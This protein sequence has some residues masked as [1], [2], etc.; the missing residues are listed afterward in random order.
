M[1]DIKAG[2]PTLFIITDHHLSPNWWLIPLMMEF[3][4]IV[5]KFPCVDCIW[6]L[7]MGLS[8][9]MVSPKSYACNAWSSCPH[10]HCHVRI[11]SI[12]EQTWI[13][14]YPHYTT[15][16]PSWNRQFW[17]IPHFCLKK[18]S[19]T[20]CFPWYHETLHLTSIIFPLLDKS[21]SSSFL[22]TKI[23]R[24]FV[25]K[26]GS[27]KSYGLSSYFPVAD[28]IWWLSLHVSY[29]KEKIPRAV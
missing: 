25:W 5:V 12:L 29:P 11:P 28:A 16:I 1:D 14:V 10:Y 7:Y 2:I 6:W 18:V 21:I 19:S 8:G 24:R 27:P 3:H 9:N 15:I 13:L 4:L 26:S 20:S 23:S 22:P 17:S